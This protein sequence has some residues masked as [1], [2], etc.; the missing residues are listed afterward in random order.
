MSASC[1]WLTYFSISAVLHVYRQLFPVTLIM[2]SL[3]QELRPA[4]APR[5]HRAVTDQVG[6]GPD[7]S[8]RVSTPLPL[9]WVLFDTRLFTEQIYNRN[10]TLGPV[11]RRAQWIVMLEVLMRRAR[12]T[13]ILGNA[14]RAA[15]I[16]A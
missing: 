10:G 7:M 16:P 13:R 6:S 9:G 4:S 11:G 5:A 1:R 3:R 12:K 8:Y 15:A 14:L 2:T